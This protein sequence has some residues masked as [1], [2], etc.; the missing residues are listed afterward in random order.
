MPICDIAA[1]LARTPFAPP[2]VS[3]ASRRFL[4]C[5]TGAAAFPILLALFAASLSALSFLLSLHPT[6][7]GCD[8]VPFDMGTG[9]DSFLQAEGPSSSSALLT[10]ALKFNRV[11]PVT[12]EG[13][14]TTG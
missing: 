5:A 2:L 12:T 14:L 11:A 10:A 4:F 6:D 9:S 8:L 7:W 13:Q 3:P 1:S